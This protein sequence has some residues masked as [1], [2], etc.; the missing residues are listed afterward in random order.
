MN[1]G[2]KEGNEGEGYLRSKVTKAQDQLEVS[3]VKKLLF[4]IIA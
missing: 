2:M 3:N 4:M 1:K